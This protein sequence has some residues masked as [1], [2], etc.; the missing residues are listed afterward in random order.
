VSFYRFFEG[1][2]FEPGSIELDD[3]IVSF[4][5]Q[6]PSGKSYC[7]H[8]LSWW[9]QRD[10]DNVLLLSFEGMKADPEN[11]IR[12]V[13]AF[14]GIELD[15]ELLATTLEISSLDFMKANNS[16]FD[17]L[18]MR[19]MSERVCNLPA[20]SDSAKVREGQVGGG[21]QQ[22]S[23]QA[24]AAM[25]ERWQQDVTPTSG[26]DDYGAFQRVIEARLTR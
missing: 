11:T 24:R 16:K 17:D 6:R 15:E 21:K 12:R 14:S 13:A 22:L 7:E 23:E 19:E 18:L 1:W 8:L 25:A 9:E 4:Y 20:G 3:F 10:S 5:L 26:F 2:F